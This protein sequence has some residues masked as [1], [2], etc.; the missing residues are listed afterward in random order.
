MADNEAVIRRYFDAVASGDRS[1]LDEIF[2]DDITY[3]YPG[4][5][6]FAGVYHGKLEIFDYIDRLGA[7]LGGTLTIEVDDILAN[8]RRAVGVVRP[9]ARRKGHEL[10]WGLLILFGLTDG[11]IDRIQLHYADQHAFDE[12]ISR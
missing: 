4:R 12:F 6:A 8:D 3:R 9:K 7:E 10:E 11:K 1:V 5:S 2:A